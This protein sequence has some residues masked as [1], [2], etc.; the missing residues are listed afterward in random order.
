MDAWDHTAELRSLPATSD[1]AEFTLYS[2]EAFLNLQPGLPDPED[3]SNCVFRHG[4]SAGDRIP[5]EPSPESEALEYDDK[6][7]EGPSVVSVL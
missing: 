2:P 7:L 5:K 4:P 3:S 6:K 1:L